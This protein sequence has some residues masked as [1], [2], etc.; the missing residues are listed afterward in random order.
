MVFGDNASSFSVFTVL[1]VL[2]S[3]AYKGL[4]SNTMPSFSDFKGGA[5][6]SSIQATPKSAAEGCSAAGC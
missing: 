1:E 6:L 3:L 2:I 5:S 4:I